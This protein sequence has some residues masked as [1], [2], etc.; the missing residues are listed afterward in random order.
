MDGGETLNNRIRY[1]LNDITKNQFY[2]MP[3]FLFEGEFTELS[4]N[5]RVLYSQLRDRHNLSIKNRWI[6]DKNEVYLIYT[7]ENMAKILGCS[8]PTI[9]KAVNQ[10]K[11]YGLVEEERLGV[12]KANRI[13][14]TAVNLEDDGLKETFTQDCKNLS[15]I[16]EKKLQSGMKESYSLEEKKFSGNKT[17]INKTDVL[18]QSINHEVDM[19]SDYDKTCVLIEK[20]IDYWALKQTYPHNRIIDDILEIIVDVLSSSD[21]VIRVNKENKAAETVK[22]MFM[23]LQYDH[24]EYVIGVFEKQTV[25]ARNIKAYLITSLYNAPMTINAYY[26]N[27]VSFDMANKL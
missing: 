8:Q 11:E 22:S 24:I 7:R 27:L 14:L 9:R 4:N 26:T 15:F 10:L 21:D 13:Y 6:N 12:N 23:K 5:A 16:S 3:K 25:K 2:Q 1:T 20:Q 18:N 17:D 19:T